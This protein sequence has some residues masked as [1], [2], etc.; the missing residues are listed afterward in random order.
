MIEHTQ[1]PCFPIS[2]FLMSHDDDFGEIILLQDL[3][4]MIKVK[5]SLLEKIMIIGISSN[6]V[7]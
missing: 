1:L 7:F 4:N 2:L 3:L 5:S 6:Q